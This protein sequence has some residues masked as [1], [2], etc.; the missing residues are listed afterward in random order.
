MFTMSMQQGAAPDYLRGS[1]EVVDP[2][3]GAVEALHGDAVPAT[4]NR[5][6]HPV[7]N[8]RGDRVEFASEPD[9]R[10]SITLVTATG[11]RTTVMSGRGPSGYGYSLGAAFWS[12]DGTWIAADDG[13]ILVVVPGRRPSTR[14]LVEH[15]GDWGFDAQYARFALSATD[16]PASGSGAE[17]GK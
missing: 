15:P 9:G 7:L 6:T 2:R 13:R 12:P 1:A 14:V 8:A 4:P 11:S 16:L 17:P 10:V 5:T 3:T